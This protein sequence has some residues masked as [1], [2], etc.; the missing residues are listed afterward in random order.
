MKTTKITFKEFSRE[1]A[2]EYY[3]VLLNQ[4]KLIKHP[5]SK[6][7]FATK[8]FV[9]YVIY[10]SFFVALGLFLTA[11]MGQL[12][13]LLFIPVLTAVATIH[14]YFRINSNVTKL[15]HAEASAFILTLSDN[16]IIYGQGK[17]NGV[18]MLWQ[19]IKKIIFTDNSIIFLPNA[20][21]IFPIVVPI[22]AQKEIKSILK[23]KHI[24]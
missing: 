2:E 12:W 10:A 14:T 19:E 20:T 11:Y 17:D 13:P 1:Y 21:D 4:K 15:Q 8:S 16:H 24:E 23:K 18:I 7:K 9:G 22:A 3:Y 5:E 6:I